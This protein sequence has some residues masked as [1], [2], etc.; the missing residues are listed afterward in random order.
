MNVVNK[1]STKS[2]KYL[3]MY[4]AWP[5]SSPPRIMNKMERMVANIH[6]KKSS[7]M[8]VMIVSMTSDTP[9]SLSWTKINYKQFFCINLY[10][11]SFNWLH[12]SKYFDKAQNA[13]GT[14]GCASR[15][16]VVAKDAR[17]WRDPQHW[18]DDNVKHIP[19]IVPKRML[20]GEQF[21]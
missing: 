4:L 20:K 15:A 1:P 13:C 8:V 3:P 9:V 17:I 21:D 6:K 14:N 11:Q 16:I 18:H 7:G 2:E 12:W 19:R 5:N 10:L